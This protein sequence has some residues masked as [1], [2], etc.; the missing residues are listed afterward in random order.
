MHGIGDEWLVE[1]C[2]LQTSRTFLKQEQLE[3][4]QDMAL[5][6]R[7]QDVYEYIINCIN[8][9]HKTLMKWLKLEKN[10]KELI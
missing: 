2:K 9:N 10:S 1:D 5:N 8:E 7:V 6:G 4:V 3:K